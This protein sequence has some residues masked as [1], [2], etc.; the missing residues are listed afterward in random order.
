MLTF[1]NIRRGFANNSS[2]SHSMLLMDTSASSKL[3]SKA[4][5]GDYGWENFTLTDTSSKK[6]YVRNL[7]DQALTSQLGKTISRQVLTDLGLLNNSKEFFLEKNVDHQSQIVLPLSEDQSGVNIQF[8]KELTDWSLQDN[9][10]ILGGNDNSKGHPYKKRGTNIS[11]SYWLSE[12]GIIAWKDDATNTWSLFSKKNGLSLRFSFDDMANAYQKTDN[13]ENYQLSNTAAL[14]P[15]LVDIKITDRCPF[16]CSYCYQ[17]STPKAPHASLESIVDIAQSL[18]SQQVFEV[19]LGG[20]EPTLHPNFNQII[21]E[22]YN[23]SITPNFTTRNLAWLKSPL[24]ISVLEKVGGFAVSVD[25]VKGT[26]DALDALD[27][28]G[29][30]ATAAGPCASLRARPSSSSPTARSRLR[31]A[32]PSGGE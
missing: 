32:A 9:I 15:N 13:Y 7:F 21:D 16:G 2:S 26:K 29:D 23:R 25:T 4:D 6:D 31:L 19:A 5:D 17:G 10:A 18:A 28:Q 3:K 8:M 1:F 12:A 24:S 27:A 11:L 14:R 30:P 22:F 20:G